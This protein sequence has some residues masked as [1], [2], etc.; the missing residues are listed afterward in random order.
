MSKPKPVPAYSGPMLP[1][2]TKVEVLRPNIWANSKGE[3]IGIEGANHRCQIKK[4]WSSQPFS[5]LAT[6]EQ[7]KE[8]K[9]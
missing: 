3:V 2:G 1:I 9:P 6:M 7:L 8:L 5:I 4:D